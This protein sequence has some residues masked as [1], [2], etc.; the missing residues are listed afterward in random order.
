M[1]R[2][3]RVAVSLLTLLG[4]PLAVGK[5]LLSPCEDELGPRTLWC[6]PRTSHTHHRGYKVC[7][8]SLVP[9]VQPWPCHVSKFIITSYFF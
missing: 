8:P 5:R 1:C 7:I 3:Y 6:K 2:W 4:V 9:A